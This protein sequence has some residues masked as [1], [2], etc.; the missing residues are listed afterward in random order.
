MDK[1]IIT[2]GSQASGQER[3]TSMEVSSNISRDIDDS[4]ST[5]GRLDGMMPIYNK[6]LIKLA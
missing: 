2:P 6:I 5:T 4:S 1:M 3:T